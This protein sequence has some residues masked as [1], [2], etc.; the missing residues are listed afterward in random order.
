MRNIYMFD[1]NNGTTG[2]HDVYVAT[3][4]NI[5]LGMEDVDSVTV[6]GR[7]SPVLIKN[8]TYDD[9]EIDI[10]CGFK[11]ADPDLWNHKVREISKWLRG[12]GKL[13]FSDAQECFYKVKRVELKEIERASKKYGKFE[14]TFVC[15]PFVYYYA[16][17]VEMTTTKATFNPYGRCK[18][19]YMVVGEG[20]FNLSVN[21][22]AFVGDISADTEVM[23]I[24]SDKMITYDENKES[25]NTS[26]SGDYEGLWLESGDNT[27]T[28]TRGFTVHV[29]PNWRDL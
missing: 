4:P 25:K 16:G 14:V 29:V 23:I 8:G 12:S 19:L 22:N 28:Y 3:R 11:V 6:A 10:E 24:D 9:I 18:P 7:E 1:F 5:P 20:T 26:V 21:G 13:T 15:E 17:Q 27:I 2:G